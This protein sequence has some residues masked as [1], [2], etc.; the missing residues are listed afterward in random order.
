MEAYF[1][2]RAA[3]SSVLRTMQVIRAMIGS[4]F[5]QFS[6]ESSNRYG[7][8][9]NL[10]LDVLRVE[11]ESDNELDEPKRLRSSAVSWMSGW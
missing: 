7:Q 8:H 4:C 6:N 1:R 2:C 9:G 3:M 11:V 5:S 10:L